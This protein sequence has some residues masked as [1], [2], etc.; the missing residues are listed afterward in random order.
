M[1]AKACVDVGS[2]FSTQF[3]GKLGTA[4]AIRFSLISDITSRKA[5][6]RYLIEDI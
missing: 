2:N 6:H 3:E 5:T 1:R 4:A